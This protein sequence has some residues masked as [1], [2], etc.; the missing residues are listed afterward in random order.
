MGLDLE[1]LPLGEI[2]QQIRS[3]QLLANGL[4]CRPFIA[5]AKQL[6]N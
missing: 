4:I 3:P 2:N 5:M 6:K 1:P